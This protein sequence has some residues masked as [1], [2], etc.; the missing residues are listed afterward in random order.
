EKV[1]LLFA[2]S[3]LIAAPPVS[4]EKDLLRRPTLSMLSVI[5][6]QARINGRKPAAHECSSLCFPTV[7]ATRLAASCAHRCDFTSVSI[8]NRGQN[9]HVN[10]DRM[11]KR[12]AHTVQHLCVDQNVISAGHLFG[13]SSA[14]MKPE[15]HKAG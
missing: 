15:D 6:V 12:S 5:G 9:M 4:A 3:V 8:T 2:T 13:N 11:M 1:L 7:D 10:I 14:D